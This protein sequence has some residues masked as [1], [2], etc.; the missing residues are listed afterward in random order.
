MEGRRQRRRPEVARQLILDAA[1]ALLAE[2][3][4]RAVQVRAVGARIGMT[5]AGVIH[6]FKSRD[7]LLQELL[8]HAGRQLRTAIDTTVASWLDDGADLDRLVNCL[9]DMYR[10]GYSE[11]AVALHAAGW[12]DR[13]SGMLSPLVDAL[14]ALRPPGA[15]ID[16][17]RLAVAALHQAVALEP[18]Y[19]PSFRRS[20]GFTRPAAA[21]ATEQLRWWSQQ[22][23]LALELEVPVQRAPRQR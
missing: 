16:E 20:A 19:G 18:L 17:T 21:S 22:L 7:I 5:D 11:L 15:S 1:A 2:G 3:G 14:H 23:A 6:H 4:V 8:R 13:G 10:Q 12:R 9:L